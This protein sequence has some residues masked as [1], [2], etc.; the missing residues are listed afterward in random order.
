[1]T[2][3]TSGSTPDGNS[4]ITVTGTGGS[5]THTTSFNL[6]VSSQ[7]GTPIVGD[8]NLDHIVNSVDFSILNAHW[9]TNYAQADFNNDGLVNAIDFSMLNANWFRTW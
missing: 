7:S 4:T 3:S 2:I 6:A 5:T 1:M 8:I 9:F